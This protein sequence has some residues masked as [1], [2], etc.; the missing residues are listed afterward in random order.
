MLQ[1]LS[2]R[3]FAIISNLNIQF[4]EGMTV[5]T[6]ETGA[7]KSIVIDAVSL[8]VGAR[9]STDYIRAEE[10]KC[11]LEGLFTLPQGH[12]IFDK[13]SKKGIDVEDEMIVIQR[14]IARNGKNTCRINGHLVNTTMLKEIGPYLV[15][16]QGQHD[17]Q[18]LMQPEYHLS[19]LDRFGNASLQQLKADYLEAFENYK[20][21]DKKLKQVQ[22]NEQAYAQRM[23]ML[24]Y[25]VEEIEAAELEVGEEE[26]LTEERHKL[27]NFQRLADELSLSYQALNSE[28]GGVL[29]ALSTVVSALQNIEDLSPHYQEMAQTA[30]DLFYSLQDL[31]GEISGEIDQLEMDEARLDFIEDRLREIRNLERKYGSNIEEVLTYYDKISEELSKVLNEEYNIDTLQEK[32][33][34]YYEQ[35]QH[36]GKKLSKERHEVAYQLT[37][38][39]HHELSD[40]YM[41]HA[42]FE[43]RFETLDDPTEE[44]LESVSFYIAT[45]KGEESKPLQKVVSGGE[46]SRVTLALKTMFIDSTAVTSIIFDEVDTGVSGRVAQAIAEKI[47]QIAS[48]SQVLCITHLPQVAAIADHHY[49]IEKNIQNDRTLMHWVEIEDEHRTQEIARMLTGTEMTALSHD[50]AQELLEQENKIKE[51]IKKGHCE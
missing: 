43:V 7:G 40:L 46:L 28:E 10:K 15:D 18:Q 42:K 45:N 30:S 4:D 37:Q 5:L 16:I 6:G 19:M 44:G 25:Q 8:L 31:S 12:P 1:E 14:D 29:S 11:Q 51:S 2:I 49:F 22:A 50:H 36:L 3:N 32:V 20:Q 23:D 47:Y 38:A 17:S 27:T 39:I 24:K 33:T 26:Q 13:L 9:G 21:W 34:Q 48:S 35:V 41:E